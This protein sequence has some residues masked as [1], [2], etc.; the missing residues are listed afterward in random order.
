[1]LV[2]FICTLLVGGARTFNIDIKTPYIVYGNTGEHFGFS[3]ALHKTDT[4]RK[5][6]VGA[7]TASTAQAGVDNGGSVYQCTIPSNLEVPRAATGCSNQVS[8]FDSTGNRFLY[9]NDE[10]EPD[11]DSSNNFQY[12]YESSGYQQENKTGQWLGVTLKSNGDYVVA[13]AHRYIRVANRYLKNTY[14]TQ[15][16]G[17]CSV[18]SGDLNTKVSE[19]APCWSDS[20]GYEMTSCQAGSSLAMSPESMVFGGPGAYQGEGK[21][22]MSSDFTSSSSTQTESQQPGAAGAVGQWYTG[23][24]TALCDVNG[25]GK[26]DL[27][28]AAPRAET[29]M[30][31]LFVYN[32]NGNVL[33][34][35]KEIDGK[36]IG[37]YFGYSMDC[38]DVNGDGFDDVIVGAPF[39]SRDTSG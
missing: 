26:E 3:V 22:Y 5:L 4:D 28:T 7:P 17:K 15:P 30:G 18:V 10:G 6:L 8:S 32:K 37:E 9:I 25:D 35:Q 38:G 34:K 27:I 12:N 39:Y 21:A 1:M 23:Y 2:L 31:K 29:Y 33:N 11:M 16:I 20:T 19:H 14:D 24:S 36:Q 13:C